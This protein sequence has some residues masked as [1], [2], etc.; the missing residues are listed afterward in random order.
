MSC[1]PGWSQHHYIAENE[2]VLELLTLL[3]QSLS[4][5]SKCAAPALP[6]SQFMQHWRQKPSC[7]ACLIAFFQPKLTS[8][9]LCWFY[10]CTVAS[11]ETSFNKDFSFNEKWIPVSWLFLKPML[12]LRVYHKSQETQIHVCLHTI[13]TNPYKIVFL[14]SMFLPTTYLLHFLFWYQAS[15]AMLSIL[16]DLPNFFQNI[17]NKIYLEK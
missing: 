16:R 7:D 14:E 2:N 3:P 1:N 9:P 15:K 4:W 12:Y 6:D 10:H 17:L 8:R 5:E 11:L 13:N